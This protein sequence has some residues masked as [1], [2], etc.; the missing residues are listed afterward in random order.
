MEKRVEK[1]CP[2]SIREL[3]G[4]SKV[5]A[6]H[7][8]AVIATGDRIPTLQALYSVNCEALGDDLFSL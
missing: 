8:L 4:C 6:A 3:H 5:M 1:A 7:I 2:W